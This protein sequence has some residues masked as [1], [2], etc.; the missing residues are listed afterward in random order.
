MVFSCFKFSKRLVFCREAFRIGCSPS[1]QESSLG[2]VMRVSHS[3]RQNLVTHLKYWF[4]F[5]DY[6]REV[7]TWYAQLMGRL[8]KYMYGNNGPIIMVQIENEYGAFKKCDK[9]YLNFL[10]A[11][12]G[13]QTSDF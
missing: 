2:P 6:M 11:E 12:T 7:A 8:E 1:T 4:F 9:T 13:D 3:G 5:T 10:K